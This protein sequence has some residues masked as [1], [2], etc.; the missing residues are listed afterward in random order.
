MDLCDRLDDRRGTVTRGDD[1]VNR[2]AIARDGHDDLDLPRPGVADSSVK[3]LKQ[4]NLSGV[5]N[6]GSIRPRGNADAQ[7]DRGRKLE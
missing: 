2:T 3:A 6:R 5:P 4:R 1:R 7:P